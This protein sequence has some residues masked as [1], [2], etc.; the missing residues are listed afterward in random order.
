MRLLS[1][2]ELQEALAEPVAAV[3]APVAHATAP[4]DHV[5]PQAISAAESSLGGQTFLT[6]QSS[7]GASKDVFDAELEFWFQVKL[8]QELVGGEG[9]ERAE[10]ERSNRLNRD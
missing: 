6:A 3:A 2:H 7:S 10:G 4:G 9:G 5:W 8:A 1:S